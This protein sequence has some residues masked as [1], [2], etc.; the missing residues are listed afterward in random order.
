MQYRLWTPEAELNIIARYTS[1]VTH[2][3]QFS[4]NEGQHKCL[5]VWTE[6]Q[7]KKQQTSPAGFSTW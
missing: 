4:T 2:R 6:T 1:I 3:V 5:D 7:E